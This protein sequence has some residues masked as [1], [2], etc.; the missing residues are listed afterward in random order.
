M[1]IKQA[2]NLGRTDRE[3]VIEGQR[4]RGFGEC[5]LRNYDGLRSLVFFELVLRE[6]SYHDR[7][8]VQRLDEFPKS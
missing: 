4:R 5:G 2:V 1:L 8:L 3:D 6:E 7:P